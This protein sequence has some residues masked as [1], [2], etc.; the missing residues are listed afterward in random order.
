MEDKINSRVERFERRKREGLKG[1]MNCVICPPHKGE[2]AT[3][4]ARH[5]NWKKERKTKFK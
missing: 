4:K 2:N 5:T 1:Q 3:S